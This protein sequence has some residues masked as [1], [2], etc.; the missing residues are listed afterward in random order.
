MRE[1][2]SLKR[3]PIL[4]MVAV[5]FQECS[6]RTTRET[7]DTREQ[8]DA[9]QREIN[10]LAAKPSVENLQKLLHYLR[11]DNKNSRIMAAYALHSFARYLDQ[12]LP[13][14]EQALSDPEWAV[15][16]GALA[17]IY[18]MGEKGQPLLPMV[19]KLVSDSH[20]S[21]SANAFSALSAITGGKEGGCGLT[22]PFKGIA[23]HITPPKIPEKTA[24]IFGNIGCAFTNDAV[25]LVKRKKLQYIVYDL[26]RNI[27]NTDLLHA[28]LL[29]LKVKRYTT[30]PIVIYNGAVFERP[31]NDGDIH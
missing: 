25:K 13:E 10:G 31:Q 17:A 29:E 3:L 6:T 20:E 12:A 15:R 30:I 8:H 2:K 16:S 18:Y 5:T 4:I 23:S 7:Y 14:M 24:L 1:I 9:R 21:V 27:P 11:S 22:T 26:Y 28:Y 19:R